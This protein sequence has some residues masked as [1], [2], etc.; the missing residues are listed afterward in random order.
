LKTTALI[1]ASDLLKAE[2]PELSTGTARAAVQLA[3]IDQKALS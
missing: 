1:V 3:Y 2:Y